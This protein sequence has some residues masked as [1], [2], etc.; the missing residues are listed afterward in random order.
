MIS[1][2]D[3]RAV[4]RLYCVLSVGFWVVPDPSLCRAHLISSAAAGMTAAMRLK[5][6]VPGGHHARPASPLLTGSVLDI[7]RF[8][9]ND[10]T[11]SESEGGSFDL[12]DDLHHQSTDCDTPRS[13]K[14]GSASFASISQPVHIRPVRTHVGLVPV[15]PL[16]ASGPGIAAGLCPGSPPAFLSSSVVSGG[17]HQAV[18]SPDLIRQYSMLQNQPGSLSHS[19][20]ASRSWSTGLSPLLQPPLAP[21]QQIVEQVGVG[22]GT[23]IWLLLGCCQTV[24]FFFCVPRAAQACMMPSTTTRLAAH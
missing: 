8:G 16:G 21:V 11:T 18:G 17:M 9:S 23:T 4:A 20:Q 7:H 1:L 12:P 24:V 22:N 10:T 3:A 5:R 6:L 19:L 2:L 14:A 13:A 15:R